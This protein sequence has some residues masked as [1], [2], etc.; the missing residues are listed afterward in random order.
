[1]FHHRLAVNARFLSRN[2]IKEGLISLMT[3]S[4][5]TKGQNIMNKLKQE[6]IRL[7][8]TSN[9]RNIVSVT[10]DGDP[11]IIG[12]NNEFVKLLKEEVNHNFV[13]FH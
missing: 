2:I 8:I 11:S 4:D 12:K 7:G 9:F 3:L 1:M 10:T 5:K 13:E 6:F